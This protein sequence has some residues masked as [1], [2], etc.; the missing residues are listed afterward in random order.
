[1]P[2][3]KR[4]SEAREG[5]KGWKANYFE[6]LLEAMR[7]YSKFL[8]VSANNVSSRQFADIRRDIRGEALIVMGK[9]TMMKKCIKMN[10]SEFPEYEKVLPLLVGNVGFIFTNGDLKKLRD[11]ISEF[12]VSAP[13]RAGQVSQVHVVIEPQNTGFGP[14]KTSFFQSLEIMTKINRG[15]V[16]IISP[17]KLLAPGVTVGASEAMLLN[18]LKLSPFS[19]GLVTEQC[20]DEGTVFEQAVL[21]ITEDDIRKKF[22]VG[23]ANIAS[24]SLNIGYPTMASA[25]HSMVNAF[26]RL[27]AIS[28]S[29]AVTFPEAEKIKD[30]LANPDA[31]AVAA[32]VE[33]VEAGQQKEE[34][35]QEGD[36]ESDGSI[37]LGGGMF[38]GGDDES[39]E[40][41]SSSEEEESSD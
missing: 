3:K 19:Y 37:S 29:T 36:I 12:K 11:K 20:F 16:E 10:M 14:D 9:N 40:E 28:L 17:V 25:P 2:L 41:E 7:T 30:R 31:Y 1:M 24:V 23:V 27:V 39:S 5:K 21:D 6:K 4:W 35:P 13:A 33:A 15:T 26:K 32:P 22:M 18:M 8:L 34:E 38:P